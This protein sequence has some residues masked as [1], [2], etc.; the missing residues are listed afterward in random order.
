MHD[1]IIRCIRLL[2]LM[3]FIPVC[4]AAAQSQTPVDSC[5]L[6]GYVTDSAT[7][8]PVA[9]VE[10]VARPCK[11]TPRNSVVETTLSS[12]NGFYRFD[13]LPPGTIGFYYVLRVEHEGYQN[14][15]A[16]DLVHDAVTELRHDIALAP[17]PTLCVRI[18]DAADS[19]PVCSAEVMLTS[20]GLEGAMTDTVGWCS[21]PELSCSSLSMTIKAPGYRV[22]ALGIVPRCRVGSDTVIVALKSDAGTKTVVGTLFYADDSS[23]IVHGVVEFRALLGTVP[24]MVLTTTDRHG[25]FEFTGLPAELQ[26][27]TLRPHAGKHDTLAVELPEKTTTVGVPVKRHELHTKR[28]LRDPAS[29]HRGKTPITKQYGVFDLLGRRGRGSGKSAA[30]L[31]IPER[32]G[33]T[34]HIQCLKGGAR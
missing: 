22:A 34:L 4:S 33:P 11:P 5:S 13:S 1:S 20:Q 14:Y 25:V 12:A 31:L 26:E 28:L 17:A 27:C 10:V 3:L 15:A 9:G 7:G 30:V 23:A 8:S 18:V 16:G 29:R 32:E 19:T 2:S 24:V 21:F 6:Y